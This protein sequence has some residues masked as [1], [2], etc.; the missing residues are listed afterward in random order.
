MRR[1]LGGYRQAVLGQA[2]LAQG[3]DLDHEVE[4]VE[5]DARDSL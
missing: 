3:G 1:E 4:P 5:Q 2:V